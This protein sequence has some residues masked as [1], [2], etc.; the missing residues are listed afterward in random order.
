MKLCGKRWEFQEITAL[1]QTTGMKAFER[2]LL[3][4]SKGGL[5]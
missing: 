1:L 3:H 2:F 5:L 4:Q